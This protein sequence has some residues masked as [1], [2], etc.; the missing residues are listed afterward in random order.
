MGFLFEIYIVG[1]A[2]MFWN[3]VINY[4]DYEVYEKYPN[5]DK[6]IYEHINGNKKARL[7]FKAAKWPVP[8]LKKIYTFLQTPSKK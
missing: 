8:L 7:L 1:V 5:M 4:N 6:E 2:V 3:Y